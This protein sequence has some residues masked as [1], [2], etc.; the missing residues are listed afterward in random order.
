[1]P[2][3]RL[4]LLKSTS[5]S[6]ATV[7]QPVVRRLLCSF[8]D[9][10]TSSDENIGTFT[11]IFHGIRTTDEILGRDKLRRFLGEDESRSNR[12]EVP[13]DEFAVDWPDGPPDKPLSAGCI[14]AR[15]E[16]P[17]DLFALPWP[18]EPPDKSSRTYLALTGYQGAP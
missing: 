12:L 2:A 6:L 13:A 11:E 15:N 5:G 16:V 3:H 7:Q 4:T 1:M 10:S 18:V 17:P 9:V 8:S 14:P